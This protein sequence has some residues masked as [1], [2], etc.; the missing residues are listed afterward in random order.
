MILCLILDFS[1]Y[2]KGFD[3]SISRKSSVTALVELLISVFPICTA[4]NELQL[5][6]SIK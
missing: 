5:I 3:L 6:Q 1:K 2:N 4:L